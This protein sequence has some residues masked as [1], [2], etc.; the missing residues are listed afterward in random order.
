MI[1][2]E[3]AAAEERIIAQ[4]DGKVWED[5]VEG[6][7]VLSQYRELSKSAAETDRNIRSLLEENAALAAG[8]EE[9]RRTSAQADADAREVVKALAR[10]WAAQD[11]ANSARL[12]EMTGEVSTLSSQLR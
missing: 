2:R 1:G 10:E 4:L 9:E 8:Y 11:K 12:R 3:A 6:E 7:G 5:M